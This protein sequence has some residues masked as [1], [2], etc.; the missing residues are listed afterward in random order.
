MKTIR[1]YLVPNLSQVFDDNVMDS[2]QHAHWFLDRGMTLTAR[3]S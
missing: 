1:L 3:D 2:P